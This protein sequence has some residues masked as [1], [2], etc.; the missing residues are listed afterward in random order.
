MLNSP[1]FSRRWTLWVWCCVICL[2]V[3]LANAQKTDA[4]SPPTTP[5]PEEQQPA[6]DKPQQTSQEK[7]QEKTEQSSAGGTQEDAVLQ[8]V[9]SSRSV[10]LPQVKELGG[11]GN[12]FSE[13]V[14]WLHVGPLGIRSAD[15]FYTY[16][17]QETNVPGPSTNLSAATFHANIAYDQHLQH[18]RL[19]W[20][21]DPRLL[22]VN[23]HFSQQLTN[24]DSTL[25][26]ILSPTPRL[27]FGISDWFS[28]YGRQNTFNDRSLDRNLFTG[29]LTNPFLNNGQQTLMNSFAIPVSYNTSARTTIAISPFFSYLRISTVA[30]PATSTLAGTETMFQYGART[31]FTH[32][33]SPN[34]T[35]G[36][37]YAY[38]E[39]QQKDFTDT[40]YFHSF[41]ATLSRRL[42]RSVT[43]SG[44]AGGSRSTEADRTTWT[45]VGSVT[46]TK[47]FRRGMFQITYGRDS[48]FSGFLNNGYSDYGWTSYSHHLG[49]KTS[50]SAG[51]GYLSGPSQ[52]GRV[53]GKY[54]NGSISYALYR[55]VSWF[56]GYARFWQSGSGP[57]LSLSNQQQFQVGLRWASTRKAG[58]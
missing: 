14:D 55:N 58:L 1:W 31:Q 52:G 4:P 22:E 2:M 33:F 29:S 34:L 18:S 51:F 20:Q 10:D 36:A 26:L 50:T 44:Q 53:R 17:T 37:F 38:Q 16:A 57:Q 42:G 49:R 11:N 5:P 21:Y 12:W 43:L 13:N 41:G 28:Y 9:A 27:T 24:Q 7:A 25:D 32:A 23:G 47:A 54:V 30:D 3:S 35:M 45:G 56:F 39:S 6:P 40:T 15:V 46:A 8:S 48:T 19:I